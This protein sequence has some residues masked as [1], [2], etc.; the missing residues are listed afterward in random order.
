M[1]TTSKSHTT[2][3]LVGFGGGG[4]GG[5]GL[6]F[7]LFFVVVVWLVGGLLGLVLFCFQI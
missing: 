1:L 2:H 7:V 3:S 6:R 4:G 5:V